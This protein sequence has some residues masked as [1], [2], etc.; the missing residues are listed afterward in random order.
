MTTPAGVLAGLNDEQRAAATHTGGPLLIL[1]G[2]GSGK[3]RTLV[4]RAAWLRAGG[5]PSSRILLLTDR[6]SVV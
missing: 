3:T 5:V 4:A 2:A 6:K 1:A